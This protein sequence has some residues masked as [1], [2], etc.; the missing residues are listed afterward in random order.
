MSSVSGWVGSPLNSSFGA[1]KIALESIA[2]SLRI[3][4]SKWNISVSL[5]ELGILL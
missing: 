2:D 3:E 5:I 1:S 4:L